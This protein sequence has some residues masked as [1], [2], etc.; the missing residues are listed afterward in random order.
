MIARGDEEDIHLHTPSNNNARID[1]SADV[2]EVDQAHDERGYRVVSIIHDHGS[3]D[4]RRRI[5]AS[6]IQGRR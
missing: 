2:R 6:I 4:V 1:V 5:E 3:L